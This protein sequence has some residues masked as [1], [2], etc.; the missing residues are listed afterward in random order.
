MIATEILTIGHSTLA[1]ERFVSLLAAREVA[2]LVDVRRY[3]ASRRNPQFNAD[4]LAE[5]LDRAGMDYAW[6]GDS[7]GGRRRPRQDSPN[8]GWRVEGFRGYA[9]H[10]RTQEFETGVER[11]TAIANEDGGQR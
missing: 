11:V 5:S 7:L 8:S 2:E 9:D 10:M 4:A 1:A 6:L 3:P